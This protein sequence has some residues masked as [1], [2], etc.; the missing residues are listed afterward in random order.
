MRTNQL[1]ITYSKTNFMILA[2]K[3]VDHK[4][5]IRIGENKLQQTTHT[6]YLGIMID[7][8]LNW[9]QHVQYLNSKLAR[10]AWAISELKHYVDAHTLKL[11]YNSSIYPYLKYC[12]TCWG[13]SSHSTLKPIK[14]IQKRVVRIITRS[15]YLAPS[16]PLFFELQLLKLDDIYKIEVAKILHSIHHHP[17][18]LENQ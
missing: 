17:D 18:S 8:Q 9:K 15:Q 5:D 1:T 3:N 7:D 16:S 6:K 2:K 12:I 11:L 10:G 4:F 14:T 13:L